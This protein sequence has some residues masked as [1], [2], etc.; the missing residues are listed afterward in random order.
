[1]ANKKAKEPT[2]INYI[3]IGDKVYNFADL[4][5]EEKARI[6]FLLNKQALEHIGYRMSEKTAETR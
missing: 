6:G 1:M 5:S 3:H 2:I 4:S